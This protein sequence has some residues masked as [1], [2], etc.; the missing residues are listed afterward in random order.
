MTAAF[1]PDGASDWL[2]SATRV[3]RAEAGGRGDI[4]RLAAAGEP[5]VIPGLVEGWPILAAARRGPDALCAYLLARDTGAPV[6][7]METPPAFEGRFGY[8]AG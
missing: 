8:A 2:D 3:A 1:T 5:A 6:P 7:V 4:E